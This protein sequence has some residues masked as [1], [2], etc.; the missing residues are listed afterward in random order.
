MN[1]CMHLPRTVTS[2]GPR[3]ALAMALPM[4]GFSATITTRGAAMAAACLH[5]VGV[6]MVDV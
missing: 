1:E 4:E 3:R 6:G 5:G 2:A